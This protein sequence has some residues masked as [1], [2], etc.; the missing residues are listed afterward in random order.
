MENEIK[1][2]DRGRGNNWR[3]WRWF[4]IPWGLGITCLAA[5]QLIRVLRRENKKSAD[6][7]PVTWQVYVQ[8]PWLL[9]DC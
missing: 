3:T 4:G 6:G 2:A 5:L 9:P 8:E 1:E 7:E